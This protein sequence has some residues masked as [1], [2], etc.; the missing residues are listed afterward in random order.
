MKR[1][2]FQVLE[3]LLCV[4][5]GLQLL[6]RYREFDHLLIDIALENMHRLFDQK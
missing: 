5:F 2:L 3:K 6:R 4:R 1:A